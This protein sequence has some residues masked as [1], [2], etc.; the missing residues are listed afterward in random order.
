MDA[1]QSSACLPAP[2]KGKV[3]YG[4]LTFEKSLVPV[5]VATGRRPG[6]TLTVIGKQH[7]GEFSGPAALDRV[8][9]DLKPSCMAGTLIGLPFVNP[10]QLRLTDEEF[11]KSWR[12]PALNMNRQ[13]PGDARSENPLSRLAAFIWETA[14]TRSDALLDYHCCRTADPRFAACLDGHR[15]SED[16]AVATGLEAVDLQTGGSYAEGLLIFAGADRLGIPSVLVESHPN[17]FQVREAVEACASSLW[18]AMVHLGMLEE[19][20]ATERAVNP[21]IPLFRRADPAHDIFSGHAGYLGVRKWSG[22][23]VRRGTVVGVVRSLET[24]E[25]LE[26]LR[27]PLAGSLGCIAGAE[28]KALVEKGTLVGDVKAVRWR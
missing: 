9:A 4:S 12:D 15:P 7:T 25:T 5:V 13:W 21:G 18:R 10:L 20:P 14:L 8:L 26:E 17:H 27:S 3:V 2:V 11:R 16:L 22:D 6:P 19:E 24:F 28:G 1:T 23:Q